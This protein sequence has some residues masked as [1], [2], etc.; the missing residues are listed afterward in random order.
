MSYIK[1]NE[2]KERIN[3]IKNK[4]HG[5][6]LI[7]KLEN[8]LT[9]F[10][11]NK[12]ESL[13][14]EYKELSIHTTIDKYIIEKLEYLIE[15]RKKYYI[16]SPYN[17][18]LSI[19]LVLPVACQANCAFC[20]Y[21]NENYKL[22]LKKQQFLDNF[23]NSLIECSKRAHGKPMSLD[24][25]GGEPTID[26][27]FLNQVMT[28]IKE[29]NVKSL[30]KRVTLTTNGYQAY[31]ALPIISGVVDYLNI[32]LHSYDYKTRQLK[33]KTK[34]IPTDEEL[35]KIIFEA[36]TKYNI[37]VSSVFVVDEL[38]KEHFDYINEWCYQHSFVTNRIRFNVYK[39]CHKKQFAK[40]L[41]EKSIK[42]SNYTEIYSENAEEADYS[43][44]CYKNNLLVFVLDGIPETYDSTYG[45]EILVRGDGKAYIDYRGNTLLS[46]V[47]HLPI[48]YVTVKR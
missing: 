28:I 10:P 23:V 18:I 32:S 24:I 15:F 8:N 25:T 26:L 3:Y 12:L 44:I 14:K 20:Y 27:E 9:E 36:Y 43:I 29:K 35:D 37:K 5:I 39:D 4:P 30:F 31:E 45:I 6:D 46:E 42:D 40:T 13:L 47:P 41:V 2:I 7:E 33:F 38:T 19:K 21:N 1:W 48:N 22:I 11:Q 17:N 16:R 34:Y